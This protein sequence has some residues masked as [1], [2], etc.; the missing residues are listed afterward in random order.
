MNRLYRIHTEATTPEHLA[1]IRRIVSPQFDAYNVLQG[2][3]VWRGE[4]EGSATIEVYGDATDAGVI[5]DVANL[6]KVANGQEC[7]LV[8]IL[9]VTA[10]LV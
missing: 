6:I 8:A 5:R 10:V 1:N 9:E 2:R 7:V 3:G 4:S